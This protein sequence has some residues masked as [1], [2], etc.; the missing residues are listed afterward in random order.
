[1]KVKMVLPIQ[2]A[3]ATWVRKIDLSIC[4]S[5][6]QSQSGRAFTFEVAGQPVCVTSV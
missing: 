4:K 3:K 5:E 6:R 2:L 1:M